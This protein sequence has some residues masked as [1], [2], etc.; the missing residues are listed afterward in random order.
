MNKEMLNINTHKFVI[1]RK[2]M[3]LI[4]K[5]SSTIFSKITENIFNITFK[6]KVD[7][8]PLMRSCLIDARR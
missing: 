1:S 6:I 7:A 4:L 3:L 2:H 5:Y 8:R